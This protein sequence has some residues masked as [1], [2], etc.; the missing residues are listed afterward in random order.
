[1]AKV[2]EEIR[3]A[4]AEFGKED[5]DIIRDLLDIVF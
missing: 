1:M 3:N 4:L 5:L 2:S